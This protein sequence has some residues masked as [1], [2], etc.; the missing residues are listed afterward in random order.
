MENGKRKWII[1]LLSVII[2]IA[3][4]VF[5]VSNDNSI[6]DANVCQVAEED[7]TCS[8]LVLAKGDG[9]KEACCEDFE[10]CC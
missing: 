5:I 3:V 10:L 4:L 1:L 8:W 9:Y 2:F 7:D 6:A